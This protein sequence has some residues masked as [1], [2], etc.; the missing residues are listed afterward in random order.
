MKLFLLAAAV[1]L[2][3]CA[4]TGVEYGLG[5]GRAATSTAPAAGIGKTMGGLAGTLD[6]TLKQGEGSDASTA[7]PAAK[8]AATAKKAASPDTAASKA[9]AASVPAAAPAPS[10]EDPKKI[11]TGMEYDEL[12]RRFG[13]PSMEATN[14][15]GGKLLT[16]AG[17]DGTSQVEVKEGKVSAVNRSQAGQSAGLVIH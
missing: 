10:Y 15:S 9:T 4:Q 1:P 16:Y 12:V 6:K 17:K 8:R 14:E 13:P 3:L 2:A 5:A 7:A 11:E